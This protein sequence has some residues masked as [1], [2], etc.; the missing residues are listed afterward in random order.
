MR[1][2]LKIGKD[3]EAFSRTN[4]KYIDFKEVI[5]AQFNREAQ[6][7][8]A[9]S[10]RICD[11]NPFWS[12]AGS[13]DSTTIPVMACRVQHASFPVARRELSQSYCAFDTCSRGQV[14]LIARSLFS[15][16][17][18]PSSMAQHHFG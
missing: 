18:S 14:A 2:N 4:P 11:I 17:H 5:L 1:K 3:L 9:C 15:L 7:V 13:F 6:L 12:P 16:V 10:L 8:N